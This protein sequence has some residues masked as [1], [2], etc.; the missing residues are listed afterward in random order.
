[1][2][3]VLPLP[4]PDLSGIPGLPAEAAALLTLGL[5][6]GLL[7][8][9]PGVGLVTVGSL[10][11]GL[12]PTTLALEALDVTNAILAALPGAPQITGIPSLEDFFTVT[13]TTGDS[14]YDWPLL[15]LGTLLGLSGSTTFTN[16]FAQ[17]PSLTGSELVAQIL[18]GLVIPDIARR[19]NLEQFV[20]FLLQRFLSGVQTPSVTAWIPTGQGNYGLPLGG[21]FGWL[22]TMP[23]LAVGPVAVGPTVLSDTDT[24]ISVPI[25]SF[26]AVL[27]LGLRRS[28]MRALP[29]LSS[30]PRQGF[31]PSVIPR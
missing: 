19:C 23:T 5:L 30:Q 2:T 15:G 14:A 11:A 12:G 22:A 26:G 25:V 1:M 17:V 6:P 13:Q 9:V 29:A 16:T 31:P 27:P 4:V 24:V 21:Q 28:G 10:L 8:A 18:D 20:D 3:Q 7:V